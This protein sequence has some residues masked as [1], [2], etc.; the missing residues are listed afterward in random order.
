MSL[1]TITADSKPVYC[2][3]GGAECW[4]CYDLIQWHRLMD[5]TYGRVEANRRFLDSWNNDTPFLCEQADCRSFNSTFRSYMSSVGLL[6]S[7]YSGIA[8]IAKPIGFITDTAGNSADIVTNTLK[9]LK[10]IVPIALVA[11]GIWG[12]SKVFKMKIA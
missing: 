1:T 6:D 5:K 7:L 12:L 11:V 9:V 8:I 3:F 2:H 10:W 4:T